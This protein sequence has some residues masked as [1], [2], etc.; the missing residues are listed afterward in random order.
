MTNHPIMAG[1]SYNMK[2]RLTVKNK[3]IFGFGIVVIGVMIS[4][5][6]TYVT[7]DRSRKVSDRITKI[8]TP[9]VSYL[10]DLLFQINNSK[11]LVKNWVFIDRKSDTPD[12]I[13]LKNLHK[14]E[15]PELRAKLD[16][17]SPFWNSNNQALYRDIITSITDTLFV[18]HKYVM[19]QLGNFDSYEDVMIVFEIQPMVEESGEVMIETDKI[20]SKLTTLTKEQERIVDDQLNQ[21]DRSFNNFQTLILLMGLLLIGVAIASAWITT[22]SLVRPINSLKMILLSMGK[23]ILPT[24]KIKGGDDEMGEM[25]EALNLLIEGLKETSNFASEIGKGNFDKPYHALSDDDL[26][27]NSLVQMRNNLRELSKESEAN[28]WIQTSIMKISDAL[29]GEKSA[30]ELA[31]Q[32]LS[33]IAELMNI[34]IGALYS[35]E[36]D[37]SLTLTGTYAYDIR[38]DNTTRFGLGDGLIG[39]AA[40]EKKAILFTDPPKDYIFIQSGL[41]KTPP[42]N[43]LVS[44]LIYQ[45][46]VLGVM[47]LGSAHQLTQL[48]MDLIKQV[49]ESIAIAFNSINTR[50]QM[51]NMLNMTTEQANKLRIQQEE[52]KQKNEELQVQQEELR[53]ANEELEEQ[54]KALRKSEE[55]LRTQQ[56][57][58]QVTNEELQEKTRALEEQK[59]KISDKNLELEVARTNIEQKA[60][61]LEISSKYKSEFLAN[62]SHELRTPL[63]SL[64]ILSRDLADNKNGNLNDDQIESCEIIYKSGSD[65]LTLINEILDLSK[66]ESGKMT[67]NLEQITF[68]DLTD[69]IYRQ[70][71]PVTNQ[72]QLALDVQIDPNIPGEIVTDRLRLEQILKNLMSNAIKF[73]DE[74]G[75]K[76]H[77]HLP[78]PGVDLS[79][80]GLDVEKTIAI[81]V[82]DTG[83]G[84]PKEKQ[85]AIW[86]A[87]QQADGGTSRKY[88]G[89]GL[90][91]SISRELAKLLGGEILLRS[92]PGRG[93]TFTIYLPFVKVEDTQPE[94]PSA[95]KKPATKTFQPS[96]GASETP[97]QSANSMKVTPS[98]ATI[99]VIPDDRDDIQEKDK[100]IL[101][102]EDDPSFA[103]ILIKQA[104]QNGF[105]VLACVTGEEGLTLADRFIPNAIILD[106]KLPGIDGLTVLER[107]KES[108]KTRH[109]PVHMMS[110]VEETIDVYK[111]GAIGY[112]NKPV[113]PEQLKKAFSKIEHFIDRKMKDLLIVEDDDSMRKSI[114]VVIGEEDVNITE[115]KTGDQALSILNERQFDCMVLDLGLP[116]MSGFDLLRQLDLNKISD[117]PPIIIYTGKELTKEENEELQNYTN[118]II[119]KGVK[120]EERLLDETALFLHRVVDDLPD[121]KQQ[122]IAQLH[123][124]EKLFQGKKI[125]VVD[126]D[127][128]NVFAITKVLKDK[129]MEV[130]KAVNGQMALDVLEKEAD[131][132]LI[133][134]D[135]MM[136]VM[137]GYETMR[138]IRE[139][140]KFE[141]LPVIALTA[142]AMKEDRQKCIES[143]ASDYMSKPVNIEKLLSL[144]RVWLYK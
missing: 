75:I 42:Q 109:I 135:I 129:G 67:L 111:K 116:D 26:L 113:K 61:E 103:Q 106:I 19:E 141:K 98:A 78:A 80:S 59:R 105:K 102:I 45:N 137:D 121:K 17:L 52:L 33:L 8:Y 32:I 47:E 132:D 95:I 63:N 1:K 18:K 62:M 131:I 44:P 73:T 114:K 97:S 22:N 118:S 74:G 119:I 142:K 41:G 27:G 110:A 100:V 96:V 126:D 16:E 43:I 13:R 66:I 2:I 14:S 64:L 50:W 23:G 48:Q 86:E 53:V 49:S 138:K 107:L 79:R 108:S 39:Q 36:E 29:R 28:N 125:M 65:L 84:I 143:G 24:E 133:L 54:T 38:K 37:E 92:E 122:I 46:K 91:L 21:M 4:S 35:S 144:M 127:M 128:R 76:V 25:S 81:S 104:K 60:K 11:M 134:M 5:V 124:K 34:Q 112:L 9:S 82:I 3:L 68:S 117:I 55:N 123:D 31:N 70:F 56:E 57:Q 85:L 71:R 58:L 20:V 136:P 88:G 69:N 15:F 10:N 90:G 40:L 51:Q 120:S 83:I 139:N 72:K 99:R 7:L 130:V 93:S 6:L 115:V 12:K 87:F 89:T 94:I 30:R 101:I 140:R 77:F